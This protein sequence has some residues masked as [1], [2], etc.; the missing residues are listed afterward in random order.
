[1]Q[2]PYVG[3]R[4][5]AKVP[6]PDGLRNLP[7]PPRRIIGRT[8]ELATINAVLDKGNAVVLHG[9]AGVGKTTL[10]VHVGAQELVKR[11]PVWW[12]NADSRALVDSGL[13]ELTIALQPTMTRAQRLADPREWALQWLAAHEDSLVI[14]DNVTNPS[15]FAYLSAR[16]TS[17][18]FLIT[19]RQGTGWGHLAYPLE[20]GL[21]TREEARELMII[22][23]LDYGHQYSYA[24]LRELCDELGYH[25]L[26]IEQASAYISHAGITPRSYHGL[27]RKF[28]A[29][30]YRA[31][32]EGHEPSRTIAPVLDTVMDRLNH[33]LSCEILRI[34]A[35]YASAD[36]PG[37]L[38]KG[39]SEPP[40]VVGA[41]GQL[42]AYHLITMNG[43]N[44]S[45]HRLVQ[46]LARTA[47]EDSHHRR[48]EAID[49]ARE[50]ATRI[51]IGAFL[52]SCSEGADLE[53]RHRLMPHAD[54]LLAHTGPASRTA[55]TAQLHEISTRRLRVPPAC[56]D[57]RILDQKILARNWPV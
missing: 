3:C 37:D 56:S 31:A 20:L 12:I 46:A 40:A 14:L 32:A 47:D 54:A 26:A 51:L 4:S 25:A 7:K 44:I 42:A 6:W 45:V 50:R 5:P 22:T 28:P 57:Q 41:L 10:A 36:I 24:G 13:R 48:Q 16:T 52:D 15:D 11:R 55:A 18:R 27:L 19:S 53:R 38:L 2:A 23:L 35:W 17:S 9:L 29:A 8:A 33:P 49:H 30:M 21:F 1:M 39:L 43:E 34:V